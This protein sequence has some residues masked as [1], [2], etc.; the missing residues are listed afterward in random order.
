[1]K[2]SDSLAIIALI[3]GM[4]L[5]LWGSNLQATTFSYLVVA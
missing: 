5:N 3:G 4:V 1:M 2:K